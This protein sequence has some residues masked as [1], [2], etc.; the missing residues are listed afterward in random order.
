MAELPRTHARYRSAHRAGAA[1]RPM[2][3]GL[4]DLADSDPLIDEAYDSGQHGEDFSTFA[5]RGTPEPSPEPA[6]R[7]SRPARA[8]PSTRRPARPTSPGRA[9]RRVVTGS[10]AGMLLG[11]LAFTLLLSVVDYGTSGPLYWFQ[12]KYLNE[13]NPAVKA[14]AS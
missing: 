6:R 12:A 4:S 2:P 9:V 5:S 14:K 8:A 11:A 10:A 13:V 3:K 1:G 7:A